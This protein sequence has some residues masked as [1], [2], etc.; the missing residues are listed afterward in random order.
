V[1][2]TT[3]SSQAQG[4]PI[5]QAYPVQQQAYPVQQQQQQQTQEYIPSHIKAQQQSYSVG[6]GGSQIAIANMN[7]NT[8]TDINQTDC[9]LAVA[10]ADIATTVQV[11][12]PCTMN[13]GHMFEAAVDGIQF[14][15]TVPENGINQGELSTVPVPIPT[16][17]TTTAT[18]TTTTSTYHSSVMNSTGPRANNNNNTNT[19]AVNAYDIPTT[20]GTW[21]TELFDCFPAGSGF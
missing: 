13:G 21:R 9:P 7:M 17:P 8:S 19:N 18:T 1:P 11:M 6:G 3:T 4:T 15:V 2:P 10:V 16:S 20:N 14:I 12:A 5:A